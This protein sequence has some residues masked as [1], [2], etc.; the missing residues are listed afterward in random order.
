M[1][2]LAAFLLLLLPGFAWAV[3]RQGG[4]GGPLLISGDGGRVPPDAALELPELPA[5]ELEPAAPLLPDPTP[6]ALPEPSFLESIGITFMKST[7]GERNNNPGNIRISPINWQGKIGGADRSFETFADPR[8]GIRALAVNLRTYQNVHGLNTVRQLVTRWAPA[9]ENDT[10]AYVRAVAA[11]MGVG[12]DD[13]I[14]L[15]ERQTLAD[16]VTAIIKHENGRV[17]YAASEI[18]DAV[19]AA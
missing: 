1:R 6:Y 15:A 16:L 18:V 19:N 5:L 7:R 13:A 10:G 8:A 3:T 17:I 4:Q 11:A 12:P 2:L 14:N 9:T